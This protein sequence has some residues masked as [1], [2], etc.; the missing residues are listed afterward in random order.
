MM[1]TTDLSLRM[2]PIYAP[3]S[4]R[5]HENPNEF[6]DAFAKA[7]YKLTHR[8]MG[9]VS[10]CS[11]RWF[12]PPQLWQ[13]PVPNV[14][15]ELIGEQDIAQLKAK[16]LA[17]G[18]SISQ[19]VTTAWASASTF[20]GTDKRGG[21]NGA[22]HSPG[23]A[24][25]LGSQP[26]GRTGQGPAGARENPKG[27][28][29][30]ADRR[31]EEGLARRRDRSGRLRRRR[32]RCEEGRAGCE[33]ALLAGPHRRDAGDDRRRIVCSARTDRGRVPQLPPKG[34]DRPA[35]ELLVDRAHFLTLTA[36]EMTV[37]VG[38]LRVLG[39]NFGQSPAGRLHQAARVTDQRLLRE[40]ARHGYGVAEVRQVRARLRG[41][42]QSARARSSGRRPPSTSSSVQTLTSEPSRKFYACNDSQPAFVRDFV[43]AWNKV[44]NLDRF[45]LT[46]HA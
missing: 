43:A 19:L 6:A 21:A 27:V 18:L 32:G 10:R 30:L 5:F 2:D 42:R 26:A 31:Q 39:A 1:F 20:R 28:Q 23:A 33:G 8:D 41:A 25:G 24:E 12:P 16:L 22:R 14:D 34:R 35:A 15:H 17:S 4:K 45:D 37:L 44:M 36:P 38:G 9:P 40:P 11:A 3:I 29:Q 7:W 13:D 46:V